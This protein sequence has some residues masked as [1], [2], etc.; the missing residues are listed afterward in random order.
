MDEGVDIRERTRGIRRLGA[1]GEID[2]HRVEAPIHQQCGRQA[3]EAVHDGVERKE[4][5]CNRATDP[6][7]AA[8]DDDVHPGQRAGDEDVTRHV[9]WLR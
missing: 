8:S 3:V 7:T 9:C 6:A 1:V 2:G 5:R 4:S